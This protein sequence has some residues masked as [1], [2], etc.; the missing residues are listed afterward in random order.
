MNRKGSI[1][2]LILAAAVA[3]TCW[4]ALR[5]T[6][7]EPIVVAET[8]STSE[9]SPALPAAL[10]SPSAIAPAVEKPEDTRSKAESA[11]S[12]QPSTAPAA[13]SLVIYGYL[14]HDPQRSELFEGGVVLTDHLGVQQTA[15][16]GAD[17]AYSFSG[18]ARGHYSLGSWSPRNGT[19]H[20]EVDLNGKIVET[21]VDLQLVLPYELTVKVVDRDGKVCALG[22]GSRV[23]ATDE[24]PGEWLEDLGTNTVEHYGVGTFRG[25]EDQFARG[26][27]ASP[28]LGILALDHTP[29]LFVS[30]VIYQHV[31]ATQRVEAGTRDVVIVIDRNARALELGC[32][33]FRLVD[34]QTR[35]DVEAGSVHLDG[36]GMRMLKK[37]GDGYRIADLVPGWYR[38]QV[39]AKGYESLGKRFLVAPAVDTDLGDIALEREQWIRGTVTDSEGKGVSVALHWDEYDREKGAA[40][41]LDT[42]YA[43]KSQNDGTFRIGGLSRGLYLVCTHVRDS[44]TPSVSQLVD[45]TCGPVEDVRIQIPRGVPLVLRS[46]DPEHWRAV[47]YKIVDDSNLVHGWSHLWNLEPYRITL[48]P[49]RYTLDVRANESADVK[50]IPFTLSND[51]VELAIP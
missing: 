35:A 1:A 49:G 8:R 33:G 10:E 24:A 14:L 12:E 34:A 6:S 22:F 16:C 30:F 44:D 27:D 38:I 21:R 32:L 19:V 37:A 39:F 42:Y 5:R 13:P 7:V 28:E 26:S 3:I 9:A 17:G 2:A 43:I 4:L 20:A 11:Q 48:A 50:H 31:V 47:R 40:P 15:H 18:L 41:I 36:P 29:P 25:S 45:T 46:S 51:P 23:V